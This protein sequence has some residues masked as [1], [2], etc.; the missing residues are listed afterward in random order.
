MG[1]KLDHREPAG[2]LTRS[3]SLAFGTPPTAGQYRRPLANTRR[4]RANAADRRR[5]IVGVTAV[6]LPLRACCRRPP[7]RSVFEK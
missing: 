5:H 3:S 2:N 6:Y 4:R 7:A 1:R